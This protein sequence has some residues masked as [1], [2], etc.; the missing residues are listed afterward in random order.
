MLQ[1]SKKSVVSELETTNSGVVLG[2][3]LYLSSDL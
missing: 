2:L 1:D 3:T